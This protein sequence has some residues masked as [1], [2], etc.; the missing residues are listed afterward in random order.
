MSPGRS[1]RQRPA[2][3]LVVFYSHEMARDLR[4]DLRPDAGECVP[5]LLSGPPQSKVNN[6]WMRLGIALNQPAD[7]TVKRHQDELLAAADGNQI[8]VGC[9][10]RHN[11]DLSDFVPLAA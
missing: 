4:L 5:E 1:D 6:A 11:C 8:L 9:C 7:V 2:A 3:D 10:G